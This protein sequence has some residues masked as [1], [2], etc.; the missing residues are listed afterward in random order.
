MPWQLVLTGVRRC[1]RFVVELQSASEADDPSSLLLIYGDK[2]SDPFRAGTLA[3]DQ[4]ISDCSFEG[5]IC[6]TDLGRRSFQSG[7]KR[8]QSLQ[9]RMFNGEGNP[10][11]GGV[12]WTGPAFPEQVRVVCNMP[13]ADVRTTCKV[14]SITT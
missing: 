10:I 5:R 14:V 11:I 9:L 8:R 13:A 7:G 6:T 4:H 1:P 12:S 3:P 2:G